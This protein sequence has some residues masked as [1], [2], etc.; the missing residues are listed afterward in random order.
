MFW[1]MVA[2]ALFRQKGKMFMIAFTI[3]LGASISTS[4]LNVMLGVG[5]KVNQELKTYGAN[6]N[7]MHKEASLIG[8]LYDVGE[9]QTTSTA[10]YLKEDELGNIKTIFWG[11]N[12]VD[13]TPYFNTKVSVEGVE[14]PVVMVG[15]WFAH[16]MVLPTGE[17][18]D[19]GMT[20][21]KNWWTIDGEWVD[22]G[23]DDQVIVGS[24]FAGRNNI[25]V[26]DTIKISSRK[27]GNTETR[28]VLVKGIFTAGS[29]ED[30]YIYSSLHTAQKIAGREN[31][32]SKIEV[33]AL[34]TPDND[35]AIK[36]AR[37]PLSLTIKEWEVWYCTAYASAIC[38]QIQEVMTDSVAKPLRQVAEAEGAIL[39]KTSLLMLLITILSMLGSALG[40]SNLVTASVMERSGEIGLQKAVGATNGAITFLILTEITI[41]GIIGG[42]M[43]FLIGL[44]FTNIIGNTVFGSAITL[45]PVVIPIV[46]VIILFV[47]ILGSIPAI[48]YLLALKPT[49]VLHGK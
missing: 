28:E 44:I 5:D 30:E 42:G 29:G 45:T 31:V 4:M 39:N 11:H 19:T 12:I 20:R 32:V 16:H 13:Y 49:E 22:E 25:K 43:G 37:N 23:K 21:L 33:S 26:G 40:I 2:G 18:L 24:L 9:Q 46:I 38:Y 7:V 6:I 34:T 35:L 10:K 3:A 27:A 15:T 1:R 14:K 17:E 8:E 48:R 41:V 47:T 36:A